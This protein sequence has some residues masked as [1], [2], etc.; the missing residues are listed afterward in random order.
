M[1]NLHRV[2]GL[3]APVVFLADPTRGYVFP[4]DVR[5]VREGG[6][7]RGYMKIQW[8]AEN[9]FAT[10]KIGESA[11]WSMHAEIEER[12]TSAEVDRLLYVA[13][14]RARDLL[15]IS[16]VVKKGT[17]ASP[18]KAWG[19]FEGYLSSTKE[20][21]VRPVPEKREPD[22]KP[23]DCSPEDRRDAA[24]ARAERAQSLRQPSWTVTSATDA[25]HHRGPAKR[26]RRELAD[27]PMW[28]PRLHRM[29]LQCSMRLQ[30]MVLIGAMRGAF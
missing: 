19:A 3:E 21:E 5:I 10:R 14:T 17:G 12:Y 20:L 4:P 1:M 18:N 27:E 6:K 29:T 25:V 2:K 13:A 11:D 7:S 26:I 16:R 22:R 9:G 28:K 8:K 23:L 24:L 15:V 30:V